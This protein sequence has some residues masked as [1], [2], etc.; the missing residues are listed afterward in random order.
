MCGARERETDGDR[1]TF[2]FPSTVSTPPLLGHD[3]TKTNA[4][5][6]KTVSTW[7]REDVH[8]S[9]SSASGI[10][11][12]TRSSRILHRSLRS[13]NPSFKSSSAGRPAQQK[14]GAIAAELTVLNS[15]N[16]RVDTVGDVLQ[17]GSYTLASILL[18]ACRSKPRKRLPNSRKSVARASSARNLIFARERRLAHAIL[19]LRFVP[20]V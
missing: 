10:S 17:E 2:S 8:D 9:S 12:S 7:D 18:A 1:V 15:K 13:R 5:E 20:V 6:S 14:S 4:G 11:R 19:L 16:A 3:S